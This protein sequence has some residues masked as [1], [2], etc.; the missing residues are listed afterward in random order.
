MSD[1]T[2]GL[3]EEIKDLY[4]YK[5][6]FI[7]YITSIRENCSVLNESFEGYIV[8]ENKLNS[9]NLDGLLSYKYTLSSSSL[10]DNTLETPKV[11]EETKPKRTIIKPEVNKEDNIPDEALTGYWCYITG[12]MNRRK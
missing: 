10:S 8:L 1:N 6:Q 2:P 3:D 7:D 4:S 5:K 9:I 12:M 11:E